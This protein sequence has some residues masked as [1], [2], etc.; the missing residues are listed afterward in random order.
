[1]PFHSLPESPTPVSLA[2]ARAVKAKALEVGFDLAGICSA[3]PSRHRAHLRRWLD[4]GQ[5]GSMDYLAKRFD[6]RADPAVYFPGAASVICVALNYH[7]PLHPVPENDQANHGKIA[8]YALGADY[9]DFIK[10][11]LHALADWL[12][13][14]IP[15]VQTRC[16]VDTAPI[17]ERELAARAGIGWIGKNTCVINPRVGSWILLGEVLTTLNLPTDEPIDDHCGSCTRCID[18]CPTAAITPYQVDASRCVSYLTIEHR[19]EIAERFHEGIGNWL[20]G[21]DTCQDVCPHNHAAPDAIHPDLQPRFPT[22]GLDTRDVLAWDL[23]A[24]RGV[25]RHTAIKRVK[26]PV[27][28]RNAT[29]VAENARQCFTRTTQ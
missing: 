5:A 22:G 3:E 23:E 18:A 1:M 28:Q 12:A 21:C 20:F 19:Q 9:H 15:G 11:R 29:I 4:D 13:Q 6:E 14:T 10:N 26:L 16:A 8:R 24:Y 7:A 27:L 25:L 2:L 17:L